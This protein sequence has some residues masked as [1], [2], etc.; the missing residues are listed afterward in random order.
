VQKL[1][2]SDVI[3]IMR[4]EWNKKLAALSEDVDAALTAK[5][6]SGDEITVASPELK[7][8]HK[9]SGIRYTITSVGPRD[10]ILRT[11]E[12]DTFLVDADEMEREYIVD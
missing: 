8:R 12:G 5:T 11:P 6:K 3:R 7:V 1:T 9:K 2:E 4:E 10:C